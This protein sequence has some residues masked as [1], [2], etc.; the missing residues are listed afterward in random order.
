MVWAVAQVGFWVGAITILFEE[1]IQKF[2]LVLI[3]IGLV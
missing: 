1:T 3:C 2:G